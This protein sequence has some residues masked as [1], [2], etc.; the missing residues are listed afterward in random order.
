MQEASV[1]Q[2]LINEVLPDEMRDYSRV[3]D[4]KGVHTLLQQIAKKYP[5]RY[6]D[7]SFR[8][9]QIGQRAAQ[10]QGGMSFGLRHLRRSKVA[11]ATRT[12]N[13]ACRQF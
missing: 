1:G 12:F 10:D 8:L 9:S 11:N 3:L 4:K 7:V 6:R 2:L 5:E 13:T